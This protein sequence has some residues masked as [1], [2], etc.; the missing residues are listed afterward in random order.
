MSLLVEVVG[1]FTCAAIML[2]SVAFFVTVLIGREQ[3]KNHAKY[4]SDVEN[5]NQRLA[6]DAWW[7]SEHTPT[8]EAMQR[9]ANGHDVWSVREQWREAMGFKKPSL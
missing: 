5:V 2:I 3:E 8:M 4:L 7:F 6:G 1:I 9:L